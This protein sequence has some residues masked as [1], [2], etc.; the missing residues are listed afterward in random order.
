[1]QRTMRI[2][3]LLPLLTLVTS[4]AASSTSTHTEHTAPRLVVVQQREAHVP[5][6]DAGVAS[7]TADAGSAVSVGD[8]SPTIPDMATWH[9]L[10]A[11]PSR[12]ISARTE[13]VKFV[14]DFADDNRIYF[15]QTG[16]WEIH[17][18]F[19][20][21]FLSR[22]D[23]PIPDSEAFWAREYLS[24]NRRFVQGAITHY[25]DQDIWAVELIAQDVL[26]VP[27]T[28]AAFENVRAHANLPGLRYHPIP[29][30]HIASIAT[31]RDRIPVVTTDDIFANT[32]Y[33]PLNVGEAYGYLRF[34]DGAVDAARVRPFDIVVLAEVPLDLPV[35][36]GVITAELQTPLSHVAVLSANRGTPNMALR[37]ANRDAA[38]RA[39]DGQ[40][41]HLHVT[42]QEYTIERTTQQEA[43]RAW[44]AHRPTQ[45]AH[46]HRSE[47]DPGLP[48]LA[49]I[50][51]GDVDLVGAKAAQLG[52]LAHIT[53]A[54]PLPRAFAL[55]FRGYLDHLRRNHLD[56]E[57]TRML[58]DAQFRSDPVIRERALATFRD[59]VI[60]APVDPTLLTRLRREIHERF[61][62]V[63]VRFR[64][65][66][67]AED[68]PGFN[69]AGLYLSTRTDSNPTEAQIADAL[70][71]VWASTWNF[72]GFEERTF[73]RIP[74]EE[75]AMGVLVQESIDDDIATGVA[76][77]ANP[78]DEGRPGYYINAQVSAGSVTSAGNGE[79]AEQSIFYT[80][81]PPGALERLSSSSRT[82]G[83]LVMTNAELT[84]LSQHLASIHGYFFGN[85]A[86]QTGQAMDVEF[87]VA[88]PQRRIVIVQARP[89]PV[90]WNEGRSYAR[91]PGT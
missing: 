80:Y 27:R 23:A 47:S 42:P 39:F 11:A 84:M 38:L 70:R 41:V 5:G 10:A 19:I 67:N 58:N 54:L 37:N 63:R 81:P 75:V 82:N 33:Q 88:G 89:F 79:I 26:D 17:Y 69:G 36:A 12:E 6:H 76:I 50:D 60:A 53:P 87:L 13:V 8:F 72:Q 55:P 14:I 29:P 52:A 57:L 15:L 48:G 90:R 64:S 66:T 51:A 83:A 65:S 1:M 86:W 91:P 62:N 34:F 16:R 85:V 3:S 46:L 73:Y 44:N 71:R 21:R 49:E 78:F 30:H 4:C 2:R 59:H 18:Y 45:M 61:P 22:R 7:T 68:L 9:A 28:I 74:Q 25:R 77:T 31:I 56:V 35:C 40:L 24:N 32:R 20:Q 43:E